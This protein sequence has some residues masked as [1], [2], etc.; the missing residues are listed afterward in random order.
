MGG[1]HSLW[2]VGKDY[3][4][5]TGRPASHCTASLSDDRVVV[6]EV[7]DQLDEMHSVVANLKCEL[8]RQ[9][10]ENDCM[11]E[12][13]DQ[14]YVENER[15]RE[16]V[17]AMD[18]EKIWGTFDV[19][20]AHYK[21]LE[22]HKRS[23]SEGRDQDIVPAGPD[24]PSDSATLPSEKSVLPG[25]LRLGEADEAAGS[26]VTRPQKPDNFKDRTPF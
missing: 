13:S 25:N 26:L 20:E 16:V 19:L 5:D 2:C 6:R 21:H 24:E 9:R 1:S 3:P 14:L 18:T 10:E 8:Q 22:E 15:L 17:A 23:M 7:I 4:M 11:F 12:A